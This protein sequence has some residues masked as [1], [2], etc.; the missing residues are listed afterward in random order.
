MVAEMCAIQGLTAG[1]LDAS[2]FM[3]CPNGTKDS[4][5]VKKFTRRTW[6]DKKL[7]VGNR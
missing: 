1:R 7:V 2:V 4:V 5:S 6:N 3:D